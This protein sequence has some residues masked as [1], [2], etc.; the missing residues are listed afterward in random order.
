[1]VIEWTTTDRMAA[2]GLTKALSRHKFDTFVRQMGLR[3]TGDPSFRGSETIVKGDPGFGG[4]ETVVNQDHEGWTLVKTKRA[5]RR[6]QF[7]KKKFI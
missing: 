2:D 6:A 5:K 3:R 7:F 4:S 1:M